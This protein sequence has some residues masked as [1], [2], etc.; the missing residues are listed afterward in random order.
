VYVDRSSDFCEDGSTACPWDTVS[1]G[2]ASVVTYGE[3]RIAPGNYPETLIM[4]KPALLVPW[5]S[6][7]VKIG[8]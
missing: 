4:G 2:H 1:E 3:V 7:T 6:G 5:G 8:Q